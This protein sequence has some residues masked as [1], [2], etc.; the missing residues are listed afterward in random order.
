M[1]DKEILLKNE[2]EINKLIVKMFKIMLFMGP[3]AMLLKSVGLFISE[4]I[5]VLIVSSVFMLICA[6]PILAARNNM[7][8]GRIKGFSVF[9]MLFLATTAYSLA[10]VN[11]VFLWIVPILISGLYFSKKLIWI[12]IGATIP[13]MI[14]GEIIAEKTGQEFIA[15]VE[16][17]PLHI[18]IF[19][20]QFFLLGYLF[21]LLVNRALKMLYNSQGLLEN[22]ESIFEK[23]EKTSINIDKLLKNLALNMGESDNTLKYISNDITLISENS[24]DFLEDVKYTG[25]RSRDISKEIGLIY[26]NAD[27]IMKRAKEASGTIESNG[28]SLEEAIGEIKTIEISSEKSRAAVNNLVE[29]TREISQSLELITKIQKET[30]LLAVNSSIEAARA[31]EVGKGFAV[32]AESIKDLAIKSAEYTHRIRDKL[33]AVFG[34]SEKAIAMIN[35]SFETVSRGIEAIMLLK[36]NFVMMVDNQK[37]II[38]SVEQMKEEVSALKGNGTGI[39]EKMV[40]LV[41]ANNRVVERII[42]VTGSIEEL[43]AT[44]EQNIVYI[45]EISEKSAELEKRQQ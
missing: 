4:W 20:M 35:E 31:G 30:N 10:F 17:I 45:K 9:G 15:G 6:L 26:D 25:N 22:M 38:S 5:H 27:I 24:E 21:I 37:V 34:E 43:S 42:A 12:S 7:H 8:N 33:A 13:L 3:L 11:S 32:V 14:V 2:Y 40:E 23:N 18:T 41:E 16:W 29:K 28:I 1:L 39:E 36:E 44:F 19:L